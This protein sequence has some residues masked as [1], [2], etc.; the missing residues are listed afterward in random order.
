[1]ID[2][3]LDF[4]GDDQYGLPSHAATMPRDA[5]VVIAGT[6]SPPNGEHHGRRVVCVP[7]ERALSEHWSEICRR[8]PAVVVVG[9]PEWHGAIEPMAHITAANVSNSRNRS[10]SWVEH[11]VGALP[12]LPR[13]PSL[14]SPLPC[15]LE[16][17]PAFIVGAG[18]SLDECADSLPT[19]RDCGVVIAVNA[20]TRAA[21]HHIAV[22]NE[23]ND[24]R[25]KT[26]ALEG[27][28]LVTGP[29]AHP[30]IRHEHTARGG[31]VWWT[32]AGEL[33][34]TLASW[35]RAAV[36]PSCASS[37]SVAWCL[38]R[39]LGCDPIV[40]VGQDLGYTDGRI[41]AAAVGGF[42]GTASVTGDAFS[43]QWTEAS[44]AMPRPCVP[45][46]ETEEAI[47]TIAADG[48]KLHTVRS[49]AAV[50]RWLAHQQRARGGK[51]YQTAMRGAH[52]PGFQAKP[53]AQ[54]LASL[55]PRDVP[56]LNLDVAPDGR[57]HL[58]AALLAE[59]AALDAIV[60]R[61][62]HS[63]LLAHSALLDPFAFRAVSLFLDERRLPPCEPVF[64]EYAR[65]RRDR[66]KLGRIIREHARELRALLS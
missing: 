24:Q 7:D 47:P 32:Y 39:A 35:M 56:A 10:R 15:G 44:R 25:R 45:L 14:R 21:P 19:L 27:A 51:A 9:P 17:V 11:V 52:I 59:R 23:S 8:F 66:V 54:V 16:G 63:E 3:A 48:S 13:Y 40:L 43:Y 4:Q 38:A 18:P 61:P 33:G 30:G 28:V 20:G 1:V 62:T 58:D 6:E 64:A 12:D 46:P 36:T 2:L 26:V 29:Q 50:A 41:Y 55:Q 5:T 37:T 34:E 49:M 53:L 60:E 57:A 42:G 31:Q 22:S 65:A